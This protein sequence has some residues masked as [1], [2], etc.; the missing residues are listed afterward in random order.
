MSKP[1]EAVRLTDRVYW[2]GAVDWALRDFHGYSTNRGTTYNAYLVLADRVTLIDTVKAPFRDELL[3]RVASVIEPRKIEII[4][5]DHSEMDHTGS[6]PDVIRAVEPKEVYAS[7]VGARTV[8]SEFHG[9]REIRAVKDGDTLSLGN[10]TLTFYETRMLHWPDSMI[11]HLAEEKVLFS[12]DAFGM[13]L[14]SGDLL[15]VAHDECV[16]MEEAATYYANILMPYSQIVAKFLVR[17]RDDLKL[18]P[19]FVAPDHGPVWGK[20]FPK[21]LASYAQ[22]AE[23]KPTKKVVIAYDTMWG[24]TATMAAAIGDGVAA[25][26]G[27][28]KLIPARRSN[29]AEF[30]AELLTAGGFLAGSP[31]INNSIFPSMADVLTYLRGL[32]PKNLVG[33]AFGSYGWSGEGVAQVQHYLEEMKVD[34]VADGLKVQYVPDD[35]DLVACRELGRK[36]VERIRAASSS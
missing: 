32:K 24:S 6:L 26:G 13:H 29:R 27:E 28:P 9:I 4:V 22:W 30:A 8:P 19:D 31:T 23:Q 1:F 18:A 36:T 35:D 5:S 7:T 15:D 20:L 14:A 11:S 25:A 21:I 10:M 2:V 16:L 34:L 33:A 12:Q 17:L 3:S